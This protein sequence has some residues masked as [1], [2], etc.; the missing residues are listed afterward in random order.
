MTDSENRVA[1]MKDS[2][3]I[4]ERHFGKIMAVGSLMFAGLAAHGFN[5][6]PRG[7]VAISAVAAAVCG[8]VAI[9]WWLA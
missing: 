6:G 9:I 7:T 8:L 1:Q 2:D 5:F 3:D 4:I